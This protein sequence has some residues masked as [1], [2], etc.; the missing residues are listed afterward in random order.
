[1][2]L[3]YVVISD[4]YLF[5]EVFL[6]ILTSKNLMLLFIDKVTTRKQISLLVIL[7]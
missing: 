4:L 3:G 2:F 5:H 1:M 6:K 7:T